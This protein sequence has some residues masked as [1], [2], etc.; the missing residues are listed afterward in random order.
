MTKRPTKLLPVWIAISAVI[1]IAGIVLFALMGFNTTPEARNNK[2]VEVSYGVTV[3]ITTGAEEKLEETC[4]AA[5]EA[6]GLKPIH[7][8]LVV[9][10]DSNSGSVTGD[11]KLVYT[12]ADS[13]SFA[14]LEAARAQIDAAKGEFPAT[15]DIFVSVHGGE[16]SLFGE[17]IWRG[18]IA[19]VVGAV[20]VLVYIG[21]RF[22]IG[23]ALTGLTTC[24]HDSFLALAFLAITR[25]PVYA[26]A[27][28]LYAGV[29]AV[30]SLLLWLI[31]CIKMRENFKEPSYKSLSAEEA[32]AQSGKTALGWI[33]GVGGAIALTIAVCG[34]I[35]TAGVRLFLLPALVPVAAAIYSSLLFGPALHVYVKAAFD[36]RKLKSKRYA[37]KAKA[38][39]TKD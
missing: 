6:N 28:L 24:V 33:L 19:L 1:L 25:I 2:T 4:K 16:G 32:V 7:E 12:F 20:V 8:N 30:V 38:Q 9:E 23:A 21:I 13:A 31:Q 18:A 15:A 27:P 11:K 22:G 35:A 26:F 10:I 3:E 5:F 39:E 14:A 36:K 37:G 29:A 34:G 17:S